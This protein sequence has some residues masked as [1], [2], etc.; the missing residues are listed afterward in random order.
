MDIKGTAR[1]G[2]SIAHVRSNMTLR[3]SGHISI[4]G[5]VFFTSAHVSSKNCDCGWL[6][7][8]CSAICIGFKEAETNCGIVH[9]LGVLLMNSY[10][11]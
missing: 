2:K 6:P 4:S 5:L 8:K 9:I 3:L 11:T 7:L 10:D 1:E